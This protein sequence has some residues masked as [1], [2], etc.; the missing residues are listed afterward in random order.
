MQAS[1]RNYEKTEIRDATTTL[2][3]IK[4]GFQIEKLEPT[5][6][7]WRKDLL[8]YAEAQEN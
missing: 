1:E 8:F 4:F 7:D 3:L 2:R 6:E 5:P